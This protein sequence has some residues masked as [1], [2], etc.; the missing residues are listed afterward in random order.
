[1]TIKEARLDVCEA[2]KHLYSEREAKSITKLLFE[3]IC[4][5]SGINLLLAENELLDAN[6]LAKIED[7]KHRLLLNEPIQY[8]IGKAFFIDFELLVNKN[9][10]IPRPETEQLVRWI[11]QE[12][13]NEANILDI[14]TGSACIPLGLK[15]LNPS[16]EL[17]ACDISSQALMVAKKNSERLNL[18]ISFFELDILAAENFEID[19]KLDAIVSNPPYIPPSEKKLMPKNVLQFEPAIALFSSE[20]N[21]LEFYEAISK[22]ALSNLKRGGKLYFELNEFYAEAIKEIL[23]KNG[24]INI[25]FKKD[26][27]DKF[28]MI[29][30]A[31]P[32]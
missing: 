28:R 30:G 14:G 15:F 19:K 4:N 23:Q 22:F 18:S 9:V 11:A 5:L 1:M 27:Q 31:S 16:L 2:I 3:A 12:T 29:C 17:M 6:K 10:L 8:I 32:S 13:K 24:F 20:E 26:F 21:P 25:E 7:A